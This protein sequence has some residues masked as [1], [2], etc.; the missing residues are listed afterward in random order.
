ME[1]WRKEGKFISSN[2]V[3]RFVKC[4]GGSK[5]ISV[6]QIFKTILTTTFMGT[7]I[8]KTFMGWEG[9]KEM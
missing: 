2:L 5:I 9:L 8:V 7:M 3:S 1:K 4:S 6:F